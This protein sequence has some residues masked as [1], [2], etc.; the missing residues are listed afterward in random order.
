MRRAT[1]CAAL[2]AMALLPDVA[3]AAGSERYVVVYRATVAHPDAATSALEGKHDFKSTHRYRSALRGFSAR[4]SDAQ[5]AALRDER[6]VDF[7]Q[8]D[9][10]VTAAGET[11][12]LLAGETAPAG[13]RRV[14]AVGGGLARTAA[15]VGVAVLDTGI[16]LPNP[17]LNVVSGKN[18]ISTTAGATAQDDNG[19]GTHVAGTSAARNR[20]A[21][22]V[23]VAPGTKLYAV[24]VLNAKRMGTISQIVCGI[25]WVAANAAALNIKVANLS[26]TGTGSDDRNCGLTNSDAE[27]RAVCNAAARGVTIVAAA[28]NAGTGFANSIPAAYGEVLTVTAMTDTDGAPGG[29]GPAAACKKGERDDSY[30]TYSNYATTAAQQAHTLAAPGTCVVSLNRGTGTATYFGS[31][32]AAPHAAGAVALCHGSGGVPGPCAGLT[33]AQVIARVRADSGAAWTAATGFAGDPM[34]PLTG[35]H[36]G[37]LLD[38]GGY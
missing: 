11:A 32:Q 8:E 14:R 12:P 16:D 26:L 19:H 18:C 23:G 10:R 24:K 15:D 31:S 22:V 21:G 20:G 36:Y 38:A 6:I 4:L 25:D 27:H 5:A 30:G 2:L 13:V 7:V 37:P 1:L 3:A 29:T 9:A 35:R 28:G 34:R 33:P 17:D